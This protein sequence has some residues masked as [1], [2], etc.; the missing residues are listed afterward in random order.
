M[1][2]CANAHGFLKTDP[3]A[4]FTTPRLKVVL[5]VLPPFEVMEAALAA[6]PRL[7]NRAILVIGLYGGLRAEEIVN[8]RRANFV[9]DA[10]LLGFV[11]KGGKQRSVALPQDPLLRKEDGSNGAVSY[12]V[13]SRPVV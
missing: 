6:E 13:G 10:G 1:L 4:Q 3:G 9:P 11:G 5:P 8:L 7:R 2:W 12:F